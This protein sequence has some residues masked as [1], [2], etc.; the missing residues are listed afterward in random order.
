MARQQAAVLIEAVQQAQDRRAALVAKYMRIITTYKGSKDSS[1]FKTTKKSYDDE[2]RRYADQVAGKIKELQTGDP[3][4]AAK[5]RG[6]GCG[7]E[8]DS[9]IGCVSEQLTNSLLVHLVRL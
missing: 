7:Q 2:Y 9:Q 5:V 1:T 3:D 6:S 4:A 8:E